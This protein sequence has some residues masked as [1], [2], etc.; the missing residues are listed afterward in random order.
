MENSAE[1]CKQMRYEAEAKL[2]E[3]AV[4]YKKAG[5]ADIGAALQEVH[6]QAMRMLAYDPTRS[7]EVLQLLKRLIP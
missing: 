2:R 4:I 7:D 3:A 5:P 6:R 1:V